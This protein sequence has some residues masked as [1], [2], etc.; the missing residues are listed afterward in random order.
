MFK[1]LLLLLG[2]A[3][4]AS[5]RS[6]FQ[7]E[8]EILQ[9]TLLRSAYIQ[10]R[11]ARAVDLAHLL[12]DPA[13]TFLSEQGKLLVDE[14][15]NMLVIQDT[16]DKCQ[17]MRALIERLDVPVKQV[18]IESRIVVADDS[19]ERALGL[20]WGAHSR[21]RS[22]MASVS[23]TQDTSEPSTW[24]KLPGDLILDLELSALE[25][26][27]LGKIISSPRLVTANQQ[28]AYIESGEEIP[29]QESMASGAT[30]VSFKK[31]V[32]RL[33][34][35]PQITEDDKVLLD[36]WVNHDSRGLETAGVPAI[37][38]QELHTRVLVNNGETIVLG[39]IYQH[40]TRK[41]VM[42]VPF[43]GGLPGIGR[44]FQYKSNK[45]H[46]SELMIFVT[47]KIIRESEE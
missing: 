13:Q 12:Q 35:I 39:G 3:C 7:N 27:G 40:T 11:Y 23:D 8:G 21:H 5:E 4:F 47:P 16:A 20:Q 42:A 38:K 2:G 45:N 44:L 43:L 17:A 41:E 6:P 31:A 29:Y 1:I 28:K 19:F 34:V 9:E 32:L 14:R 30:S 10:I 26:E 18:L 36:L 15:T 46:R 24:M 33:E 37:H 22:G 25:S